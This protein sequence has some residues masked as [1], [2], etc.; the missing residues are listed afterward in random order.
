MRTFEDYNLQYFY[1]EYSTDPL[2]DK[3]LYDKQKLQFRFD[4]YPPA[5]DEDDAEIEDNKISRALIVLWQ[6]NT[7]CFAIV[8]N[9]DYQHEKELGITN[10]EC[11]LELPLT[12]SDEL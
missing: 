1:P 2:W 6:S 4:D 7:E 9:Q 3:S 10:R 11:S 5:G 12:V 8:E